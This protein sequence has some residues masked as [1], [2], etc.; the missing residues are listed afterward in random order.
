MKLWQQG[1]LIIGLPLLFQVALALVLLFNLARIESAAKTESEAKRIIAT[2]QEIRLELDRFAVMETARRYFS[3]QESARAFK[4]YAAK[5]AGQ[6]AGLRAASPDDSEGRKILAEYCDDVQAWAAILQTVTIDFHDGTPQAVMSRFNSEQEYF[7]ELFAAVAKVFAA[8]KQVQAHFGQAAKEFSP[9]ALEE[10]KQLASIIALG[11]TGNIVIAVAVAIFFGKATLLR[12]KMLLNNIKVFSVG[13]LE[14]ERLTG[15]DELAELGRSF[16]SMAE[17]RT[18]AEQLRIA[19]LDMVSHDLRSPLSSCSLGLAMLLKTQGEGLGSAVLKKLRRID[20]ELLRLMRMA[21]SLLTVGKIGHGEI[22]L[23]VSEYKIGELLDTSLDALRG[24]AETKNVSIEESLDRQWSLFCDGDKVVQIL[25]NLLSNALKFTPAGSK[26][27]IGIQ[28]LGNGGYRFEILDQGPG[29]PAVLQDKL[30]K[31]FSQL[32]QDAQTRSGGSGLGL[33]IA[34]ML[35][36]SHGGQ[37]GCTS[38]DS[39]GSCFWFEL[40]QC[41]ALASGKEVT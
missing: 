1:L 27:M 17:E 11:M 25:V 35:V 4:E 14:L 26:I 37:I 29:I 22:E 2:C 31:R 18:R 16:N 13:S 20:S 10:R 38:P 24:T 19:M 7:E 9:H 33:Y 34:K 28:E 36:D 8:Q 3:P 30:F 40:P 41:M 15:N 6:L 21:D 12:M 5:L 23:N 32:G 39:G